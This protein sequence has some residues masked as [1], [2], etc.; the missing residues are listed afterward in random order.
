MGRD[1]VL[2]QV[3]AEAIRQAQSQSTG[4]VDVKGKAVEA[5]EAFVAGLAAGGFKAVLE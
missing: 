5:A 4:L 2:M 1:E 3:I